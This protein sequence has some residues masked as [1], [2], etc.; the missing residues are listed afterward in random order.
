MHVCCFLT[1]GICQSMQLA[2][3]AM[4]YAIIMHTI[5]EVLLYIFRAHKT[6]LLKRR[7]DTCNA[8]SPIHV[9]TPDANSDRH[10]RLHLSVLKTLLTNKGMHMHRQQDPLEL[11]GDMHRQQDPLE[12]KG[13][14]HMQQG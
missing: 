5:S 6:Q 1:Q 12:L 8:H 11:K 9:Y 13:D 7:R 2:C 10:P 14:M 3:I 4:V